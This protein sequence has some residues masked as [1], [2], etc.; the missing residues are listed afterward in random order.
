VAV[1][2]EDVV[3]EIEIAGARRLEK[4]VAKEEAIVGLGLNDVPHSPKARMLGESFEVAA[5]AGSTDP[6]NPP[7][8]G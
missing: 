2:D 5:N 7:P 4:I 8:R 6:P 3:R 1:V